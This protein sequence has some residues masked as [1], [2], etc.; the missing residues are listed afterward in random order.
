MYGVVQGECMA[1]AT[2]SHLSWEWPVYLDLSCASASAEPVVH[3]AQE[4]LYEVLGRGR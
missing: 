1:N 3:I 2:K 4:L